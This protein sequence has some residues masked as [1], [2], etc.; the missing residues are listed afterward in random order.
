MNQ[1]LGPENSDSTRKFA[2]DAPI[3]VKFG[4]INA[5]FRPGEPLGQE[6]IRIP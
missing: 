5:Q 1:V 6:S 2:P 3:Y 4:A